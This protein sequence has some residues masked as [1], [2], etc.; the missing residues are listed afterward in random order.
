VNHSQ[1]SVTAL[2]ARCRSEESLASEA[3]F[4]L[5]ML[6][7]VCPGRLVTRN[8]P[9]ARASG[10]KSPQMAERMCV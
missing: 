5:T 8:C 1:D 4:S 7:D 6:V 2:S 9:L 3:L 10:R